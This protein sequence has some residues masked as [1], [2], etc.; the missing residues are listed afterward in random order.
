MAIKVTLREKSISKGRKSLYLDFYPAITLQETGKTTRREFL[1]LYILSKPNTPLEK[2]NNKETI[3][4]AQQIRHRRENDLNKP[5]IYTAFEKEQLR[6]KAIGEQD[7]LEYYTTLVNK[8]KSSNYDNWNSCLHHFK[9]FTKGTLKFAD[10]NEKVLND[11][12][13]YL[14]NAK[15]RRGGD[16]AID[17]NSALSYFNKIKAALKQAYKDG[18]LQTNLNAK[19]EPIK[20]KDTSREFLTIEELNKLVKTKCKSEIM[21]TAA[22]FSA[23]TGFRFSDIV[24]MTWQEVSFMEG[25]GYTVKFRQQKTDALEIAPISDQAF[26]LMG[27]RRN[28]NELVFKDLKYSAYQNTFL[29]NWMV[30]AGIDKK[31]TF[32]NFR[33]TY[34]T[35]Q[36]FYGTDI[37]TVSK[38]LGHKNIKTTQIYAKIVDQAKRNTTDKIKIDLN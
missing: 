16:K 23:L 9:E 24:K 38:M 10:L 6:L 20:P 1:G 30:E 31:I 29:K 21:K 14:L 32:H 2:D 7:F 35:L 13:E 8:R 5:E 25:Q 3:V 22:L 12:K 36:H 19:V 34:A 33:H 18:L 4:M 17:Q 37:Y 27:E 26:Q 15:N 11:F 28:P